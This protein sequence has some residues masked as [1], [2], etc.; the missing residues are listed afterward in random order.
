MNLKETLT[1]AGRSL[2][3]NKLRSALTTVGIVIGVTAVI[4]LVGL[5]DGMKAGFSKTFGALATAVIV[6]KVEG[7][8][9]GGGA[10]KDLKDGDI[11]A[12]RKA[13]AI[14]SVIP[15]LTGTGIV[16]HGPGTQFKSTVT[17]STVDYLSVSNR[18][19]TSGAMFTEEDYK[20][21][22][23]VTL[24]GPE[25]V[26]NLFG[27]DPMAALG[28]TVR[29]GRNNF[30]VVGTLKSDGNSD[31]AALMP[32]TTARAYLLGGTDTITGA[33]A[34]AKSVQD[35]PAAVDQITKILSERHNISDPAKE[36]FKVTALQNQ[37][38][39]INQFMG[40]MTMFIVA[41]AG[42][43]LLVG[44]IGVANIM[45]VSVTE[46]TREI[47]IRKAIGARRSTIL[48]QFLIES[49]VLAGLGGMVGI[50]FGVGIVLAG[51]AIIPKLTQDFG[52]PQVSIPAI[53]VAFI[54]SLMIGLIAGG[55]PA[56]RAARLQPIEALRFQ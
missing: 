13:P 28:Q 23:Q 29:I 18:E 22:A 34:K 39:Q 9:P 11:E 40:F 10:P 1:I 37:L 49:T 56:F 27:G 7:S 2:R 25:V 33:A 45:L 19:L 3:A 24:L 8:V 38:D 15:Q 53:A 21:R 51:A 12:L 42:I 47:G 36:D 41:V 52:P 26:T 6:T 30:K 54:V 43:S 32:L 17:G 14:G 20:K 35:V 55:Y 44:A 50:A 16:Q 31:D 4:V 5:G 48:K 46:R